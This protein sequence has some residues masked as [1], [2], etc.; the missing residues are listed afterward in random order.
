MTRARYDVVLLP[1]DGVGIEVAACARR[2]LDRIAERTDTAF[3]VDEVPC[4]GQYFLDHGRDWPEGAEARCDKADLILLGAVG[5]PS[6]DGKGPVT[7]SGG[8]MAGWSPVIG[9]RTRMNLYANIRPVKLYEGVKAR[10]WDLGEGASG[11][12]RDLLH[13]L[14]LAAVLA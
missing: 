4:G 1:G 10:I 9:N 12:G 13:T 6:P 2:V 5:W 14:G 3:E 11:L 7:M 8:R